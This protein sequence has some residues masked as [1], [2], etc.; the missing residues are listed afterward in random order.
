MVRSR[1]IMNR[2]TKQVKSHSAEDSP[3]YQVHSRKI[4]AMLDE[5]PAEVCQAKNGPL[6]HNFVLTGTA[7][8][9]L[10]GHLHN[11]N[12]NNNYAFQLMMS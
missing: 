10:H 12:N 7:C 9:P 6:Q 2:P 11:N 1:D 5:T 3:V 4:V 8:M